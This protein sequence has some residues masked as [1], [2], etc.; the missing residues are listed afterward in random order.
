MNGGHYP[1]RQK[2]H[3]YADINPFAHLINADIIPF[4]GFL[5]SDIIPLKRYEHLFNLHWINAEGVVVISGTTHI[6]RDICTHGIYMQGC[7]NDLKKQG[8]FLK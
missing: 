4:I 7:R 8:K 6:R 5:K 3:M 1:L 2:V